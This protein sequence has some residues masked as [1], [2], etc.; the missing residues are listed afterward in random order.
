M[1]EDEFAELLESGAPPQGRSRPGEEVRALLA[2]ESVWVEPDP[3][4]ADTLLRAIRR[5]S[6]SPW[7]VA[8]DDLAAPLPPASGNGHGPVLTPVGA[9]G[10]GRGAHAAR[11]GARRRRPSRVP[12]LAA[13]AAL[14]LIVGVLAALV[15]LGGDDHHAPE[16][17]LGGTDLAPGATAWATVEHQSAG[18]SIKLDVR[19]LAPAAPGTYYEAWVEGREGKVSIGTFHMRGGD[20]WIYLWSGVDPAEY[21]TLNVTIEREGGALGWSGQIVLHGQI[22]A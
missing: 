1:N 9:T 16:F 20:G 14:A 2:D 17:A 21:P 3:A 13:A 7:E 11:P 6:V 18:V 10:S 15:V 8:D 4:G 5:A 12:L 19:G 22:V